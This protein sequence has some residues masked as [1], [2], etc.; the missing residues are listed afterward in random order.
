M[1]AGSHSELPLSS[2]QNTPEPQLW[3]Q[4]PDSQQQQEPFRSHSLE[5]LPKAGSSFRYARFPST[6]QGC[7][8][9]HT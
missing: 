1:A 2:L 6:V 8:C 3:L 5:Q 9:L 7:C 4:L